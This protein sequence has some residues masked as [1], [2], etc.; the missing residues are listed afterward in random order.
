MSSNS[1]ANLPQ[2]RHS[3]P[4]LGQMACLDLGLPYTCQVVLH[5]GSLHPSSRQHQYV[6]NDLL[7]CCRQ[8]VPPHAMTQCGVP[9][10]RPRISL[11]SR[12]C[13]AFPKIKLRSSVHSCLDQLSSPAASKAISLCG[14]SSAS[15]SA[16]CMT[17]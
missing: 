14:T 15:S 3:F 4:V 1:L 6:G 11:G 8:R 16:P 7:F 9:P 10:P 13:Y 5:C 17:E 2:P 12:T